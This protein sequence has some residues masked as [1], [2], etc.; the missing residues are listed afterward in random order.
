MSKERFTVIPCSAL[1]LREDSKL[2][3]ACRQNT[4]YQDGN[5]SLVS[6]H[7][8]G[9]ETPK[10]AVIREA[11][12]EIGIELAAD[13]LRLV[14]TSH[15]ICDDASERLNMFFETSEWRGAVTNGEPEKCS[16]ISWFDEAHLP[17]NTVP[18]IK[19]ILEKVMNGE[20]YSEYRGSV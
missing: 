14:H 9:S 16:D 10:A 17:A 11:G 2:L 8:D 5:Y 1:I 6:G 3:L 7:I 20:N 13:D 4:G 12:E 18:Y 15:Q 19:F